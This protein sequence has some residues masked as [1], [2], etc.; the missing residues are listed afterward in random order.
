M[1]PTPWLTGR[2]RTRRVGPEAPFALTPPWQMTMVVVKMMMLGMGVVAAA[3]AVR[4]PRGSL[5]TETV[6]T[7]SLDQG[8]QARMTLGRSSSQ[9]VRCVYGVCAVCVWG[10]GGGGGLHGQQMLVA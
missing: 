6:R 9:R 8:T 4:S 1:R 3:V 5:M 7:M 10:G 2:P